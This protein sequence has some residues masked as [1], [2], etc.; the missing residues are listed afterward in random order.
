M[1]RNFGVIIVKAV[2]IVEAGHE[3]Q[4]CEDSE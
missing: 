1:L 3:S 4:V 2:R